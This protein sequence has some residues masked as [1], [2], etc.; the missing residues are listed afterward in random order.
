MGNA[1]KKASSAKYAVQMIARNFRKDEIINLLTA[2][3]YSKLYY[4]SEIWLIP[5]LSPILKQKLLAASANALRI[6]TRNYDRMTS[7]EQ[8]H[9]ITKR[10]KPEQMMMYRHALLLHKT[11]ND[12][13]Q[14]KRRPNNQ[15]VRNQLYKNLTQKKKK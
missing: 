12:E 11:F 1:I 4:N 6:A 3:F 13:A 2:C 7:F 5:G 9:A 8:L 10:A 15:K 14:G